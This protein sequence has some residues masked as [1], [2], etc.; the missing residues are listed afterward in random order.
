MSDIREPKEN[1]RVAV[2]GAGYWGK[3]LVRMFHSLGTL[4]IVC[5]INEK[6]LD[7]I[8]KEYRVATTTD[9]GAVIEDPK[10]MAVVI[11]APAAEHYGLTKQALEAGKHVF[12]E[13]PL[14]L[15]C[16][17]GRQLVEL[18]KERKL[19]L[20]VGHI[21]EYHPAIAELNRLVQQ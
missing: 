4:G 21:L 10:V 5:D 7:A 11:A 14:A 1:Q 12:V 17:E 2:V 15:R 8:H 20:M 6:T 13:K 19:I 18:A 3:N 9:Y 16:H